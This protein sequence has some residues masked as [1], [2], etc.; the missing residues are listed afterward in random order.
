MYLLE[1]IK[2]MFRKKTKYADGGNVASYGP[3][4]LYGFGQAN[5]MQAGGLGS[6]K[7]LPLAPQQPFAAPASPPAFA[8]G[9]TM[10]TRPTPFKKGGKVPA[11]IRGKES[12][13]MEKKMAKKDGGSC[14]GKKAHDRLD[15][16]KRASGGKVAT[17]S[18][19]PFSVSENTSERPGFKGKSDP[20]WK[21]W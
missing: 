19:S 4:A 5:P 3:Q 15:R 18:R 11:F 9:S 14:D 1:A 13:G 12:E 8:P 7:A 6:T 10:A 2:N 21:V 17:G 16:P 20:W